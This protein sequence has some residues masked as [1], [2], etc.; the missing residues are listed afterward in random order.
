MRYVV[1]FSNKIKT[2]NMYISFYKIN[3]NIELE[4]EILQSNGS[5]KIK[6]F[7]Y[8]SPESQQ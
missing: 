1:F 5:I 4:W 3:Y 7:L 2:E 8:G 6:G